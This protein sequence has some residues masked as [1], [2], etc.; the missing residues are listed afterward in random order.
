MT[1]ALSCRLKATEANAEERTEMD[2]IWWTIRLAWFFLGGLIV[3]VGMAM[4][5][6]ARCADCRRAQG[7]ELL[8]ALRDRTRERLVEDCVRYTDRRHYGVRNVG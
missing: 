5:F 3:F 8:L 1:A 4:C 6:I 2:W 7:H